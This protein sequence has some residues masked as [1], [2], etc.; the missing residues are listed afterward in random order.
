M[1]GFL[2]AFAVLALLF[3]AVFIRLGNP[4]LPILSETITFA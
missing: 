3:T 4:P 1:M 2:I